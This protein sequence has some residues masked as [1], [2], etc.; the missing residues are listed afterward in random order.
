MFSVVCAVVIYMQDGSRQYT[1]RQGLQLSNGLVSFERDWP[2]NAR[3]LAI[4]RVN[5][6]GCLYLTPMFNA[7]EWPGERLGVDVPVES[8]VAVK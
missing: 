4:R 7:G 6:N 2:L 3:G 8:S 1:M 5:M